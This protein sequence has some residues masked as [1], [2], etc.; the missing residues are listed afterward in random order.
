MLHL[1]LCGA[2]M[3]AADLVP[4]ISGG[5]IA[6]I[7]GI[8]EELIATIQSPSLKRWRF[9]LPLFSGIAFSLLL[10]SKAIHYL[11][12]FAA[13]YALF[14]GLIVSSIFFVGKQVGK[15]RPHEFGA[16]GIGALL[17]LYVTSLPTM[18]MQTPNAPYLIL[19]G[20]IAA[21]AMLLPGVSGSFLLH[22]LGVYTLAIHALSRFDFFVLGYLG[23]G[24]VIGAIGFSRVIN[25]FLKHFRDITL[26]SLMGF[27]I[28]ALKSISPFAEGG[29]AIWIAFIIGALATFPLETHLKKG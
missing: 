22:V 8:Y 27:M 28:G 5:T 16:L 21:S 15:W 24:I 18:A 19:S 23:I 13:F 14:F 26:A 3:G 17:A 12:N 11:L 29:I 20:A 4:G 25:F 10:F 9:F 1:F 7:L 2:L 6:F